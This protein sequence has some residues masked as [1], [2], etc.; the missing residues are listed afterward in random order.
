M[1]LWV[2]QTIFCDIILLN[3]LIA[4]ISQTYEKVMNNQF[5]YRISHMVELN[6][7]MQ[8]LLNTQLFRLCCCCYRKHNRNQ[9]LNN[10]RILMTI[11][12]KKYGQDEDNQWLGFVKTT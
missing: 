7:E 11:K 12:E 10:N 5:S 9:I 8:Q 2:I 6:V 4:V 1:T 3:F